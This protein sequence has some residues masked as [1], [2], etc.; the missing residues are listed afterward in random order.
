MYAFACDNMLLCEKVEYVRS[1]WSPGVGPV[2]A[3][4]LGAYPKYMSVADAI[5]DKVVY[6]ARRGQERSGEVRRGQ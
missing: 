3:H 6:T 2:G 1:T 5:T 4:T